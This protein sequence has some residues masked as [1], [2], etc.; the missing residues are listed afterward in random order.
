[1][2]LFET[3]F[4]PM[5][6]SE[7]KEPF[8]S[9]D[10]IF[11]IKFDGIRALIY[12]SP[13]T[14][15]IYNRHK[16]DITNKYPELKEIQKMV[17]KPTIFDGE[18]TFFQD[19]LPNFQALQER[20]H[21]KNTYRIE[22]LSKEKP[23]IFVA[24]DILYEGKDLTK[25]SLLK[26]KRVLESYSDNE[27][28]IKPFWVDS[29]GISLFKKIK[30]LNMEGIVAKRKESIYEKNTRTENWIKIK[31]IQREEFIIGGFT[32]KKDT[33]FFSLLLGEYQQNKLNYVGRVSVPKK[34]KLYEK[35]KK[36]N[37]RKTSP[38]KD[39][40]EE[41]IYY[42]SPKHI[43]FVEFIERSKEGILRQPVYRGE[44]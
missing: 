15:K 37:K 3:V 40:Q 4:E 38:F 21:L 19:G 2:T 29:N 16:K 26:R 34:E 17:T 35:I 36:E 8:N 32:E 12:A 5:L 31:N 41:N 27:V 23:I 33:P 39:Y 1:M 10:Y 13:T 6:L 14:F 11:E 43:C 30:K 28:F 18:I 22:R 44:K 42:L 20:A 24:F 25:Y 9:K 7:T